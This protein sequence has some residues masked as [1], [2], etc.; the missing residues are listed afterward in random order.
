M[1]IPAAYS[2]AVHTVEVATRLALPGRPVR[3]EDLGIL[4]LLLR[5]PDLDEVRGFALDVLGAVVSYDAAHGSQLVETLAAYFEHAGN[6]Q[7]TARHLHVHVNTVAYRI[8]R[9]SDLTGL[10][11]DR[12]ADRLAASV[13]LEVL[14]VLTVSDG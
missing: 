9:I 14:N 1:E 11:L 6:Q 3:F 13:A 7:R 10:D 8:R 12:H 5:F 2:E 4:R